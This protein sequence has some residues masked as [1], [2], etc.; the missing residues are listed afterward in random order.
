[1]VPFPSTCACVFLYAVQEAEA[2]E[3]AINQDAFPRCHGGDALH[4]HTLLFP[5]IFL[6]LMIPCVRESFDFY[7]F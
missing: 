2:T 4:I 3:V 7:G 5:Y 1:M 6:S